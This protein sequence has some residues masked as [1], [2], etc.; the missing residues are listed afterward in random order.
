MSYAPPRRVL[1]QRSWLAL[2]VGALTLAGCAPAELPQVKDSQASTTDAVLAI[3]LANLSGHGAR[4]LAAPAGYLLLI[5]E[6]GTGTALDVGDMTAGQVLWNEAG[7]TASTRDDELFINDQGLRR[8]PRGAVQGFEVNRFPTSD[9]RGFM[10]FYS[11]QGV[12]SIFKGDEHGNLEHTDNEGMF[13]TNGH[14][15]DRVLSVASTRFTPVLEA[16]ARRVAQQAHEAGTLAEPVPA[17]SSLDVLVQVYP[18]QD[19][20]PV[21]LGA[22]AEDDSLHA[23]PSYA[24]CYQDVLYIPL[25]Q[26]EHPDASPVNGLDPKAGRLVLQAWDLGTGRRSL[27]PVTMPDGSP[28]PITMDESESDTGHLNGPIYTCVTRNGDVLSVDVTTGILQNRFQIPLSD[29]NWQSRYQVTDTDVY[30]LD[31]PH[32]TTKPLTL[33]RY[34]LTTGTPHH[35]MTINNTSHYQDGNLLTD[36]VF[37]KSIALRPSYLQQ[38]AATP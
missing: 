32:D 31:V 15:G 5:K 17:S 26:Q 1:L 24:T 25:F 37:V 35:L 9:G 29:K 33:T 38:L 18:H 23:T 11:R 2:A 6:D 8:T 30:A 10:A 27:T 21:V 7:L 14:C 36:Q 4:E 12:Q 20:Q 28:V 13:A 16:D 3:R 19:G 34:D 22:T